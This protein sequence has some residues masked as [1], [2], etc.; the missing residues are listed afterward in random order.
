VWAFFV[1]SRSW[2][3]RATDIFGGA[4]ETRQ[5]QTSQ[6]RRG[7]PD[8][9]DKVA[10]GYGAK[11][12]GRQSLARAAITARQPAPAAAKQLAAQRLK[13]KR[14]KRKPLDILMGRPA[15]ARHESWA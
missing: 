11:A 6:G 8:P 5:E 13:R 15:I 14:L 10:K 3:A 7:L 4:L 2:E 12:A 9:G 1:P